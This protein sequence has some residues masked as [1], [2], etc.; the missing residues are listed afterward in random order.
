MEKYAVVLSLVNLFDL[1]LNHHCR[2]WYISLAEYFTS[3][4]WTWLRARRVCRPQQMQMLP[5]IH[6]K[7][8]QSRS[9]RLMG[10]VDYELSASWPLSNSWICLPPV[11]SLQIWMSAAWSHVPVSTAVWT[12][13]AATCATASMAT[14]WCQMAPV[15]VSGCL[16]TSTSL[17]PGLL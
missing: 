5:W 10:R 2:F 16:Q 14:P 17:C 4:M 11:L 12:H 8:L 3:S 1:T 6:R 9:E 13:M 7:E 15:L